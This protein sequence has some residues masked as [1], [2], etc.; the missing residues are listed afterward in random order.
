MGSEELIK[1]VKPMVD[2]LAEVLGDLAEVVLHDLRDPEHSIVAIRNG[3]ISGRN[4]GDSL[5]DYALEIL[6]ES[7]D[8]PYKVNYKGLLDDGRPIRLSSFFIRDPSGEPVAMLS[9]NLDISRVQ[10]AY[11]VMGSFLNIGKNG[12]EST[13]PHPVH[14]TSIEKL[15]HQQMDQ[16]LAMRGM[17]PSRMT[18]EEK[19]S[20]VEELDRKGIFLLK[21]AVAEAARRLEVSEQTIYR[22]LR[23]N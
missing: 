23:G 15:M 20:V 6:R 18:P 8:L 19:K 2:F 11:K 7:K 21:G 1:M 10:D 17:P 4:V 13:P 16:V 5:T 22:Y 14:F 12:E 3:H 9:I